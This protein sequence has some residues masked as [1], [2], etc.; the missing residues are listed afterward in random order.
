M[1]VMNCLVLGPTNFLI[2][3]CHIQMSHFSN[4]DQPFA[5]ATATTSGQVFM[6]LLKLYGINFYDNC[7]VIEMFKSQLEQS[8]Y[9]LLFSSYI[10][11]ATNPASYT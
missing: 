1:T 5:Y 10:I 4:V 3:N 7:L 9:Y 8:N 11:A 2:N 6:K